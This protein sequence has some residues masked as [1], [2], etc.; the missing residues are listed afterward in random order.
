MRVFK[1]LKVKI[2]EVIMSTFQL[3][4][5][6]YYQ[7][8]SAF[9]HYRWG[10]ITAAK[11][12]SVFPVSHSFQTVVGERGSCFF[13]TKSILPLELTPSLEP[14]VEK[15]DIPSSSCR[16]SSPLCDCSM[17]CY[18]VT[19]LLQS[20]WQPKVAI[21]NHRSLW[22]S[23]SASL[24]WY[25]RYSL[26][27]LTTS[28]LSLAPLVY[29]FL[30]PSI[31]I[32]TKNIFNPVIFTSAFLVPLALHQLHRVCRRLLSLSAMSVLFSF[33]LSVF[34]KYHI[35]FRANMSVWWWGFF[36][37]VFRVKA[38]QSELGT[39]ILADFEEAFPSQGSK[40][41]FWRSR[42]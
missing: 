37:R 16:Y 23:S 25:L 1:S 26:F 38:A 32:T 19:E 35:C 6:D 30:I 20:L 11:G 13:Q 36:L 41:S 8:S 27:L 5:Q 2:L 21:L 24:L 22:S 7:L 39:Q 14:T 29:K 34:P 10:G 18:P 3:L 9:L 4:W 15:Q 31:L 17:N 33:M 40:V 28:N 12:L 42:S